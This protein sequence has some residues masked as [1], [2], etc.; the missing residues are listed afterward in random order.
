VKIDL[1]N[2]TAVLAALALSI[3]GGRPR[4]DGQRAIVADRATLDPISPE[5]LPDG[6]L[7]LRDARGVLVPLRK[8]DRIASGTLISD[9]ALLDLCEPDRIVAFTRYASATPVGHRYAGKPTISGRDDVERVLALKPQL[10]L[11]SDLVDG[12]YVSRLRERG[13][14]VFDLGP[15][16][17]LET[18][19]HA[20]HSIGWLIG[21]PERAARYA[22][23][24]QLRLARV[25]DKPP[26]RGPSTL[27]LARYGDKLFAAGGHTSYHDV[28]EFAGLHDAAAAHGLN[29]WPELTA[30]RVLEL[31]PE[32]MLT[33]TGM[34][35][36]LCRHPGLSLS[37]PCRGEGKILELD[38]ALLDDPGPSM[39]DAAEA[40][41]RTYMQA[42]DRGP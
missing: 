33:R 17:G 30:E 39:L 25:T 11:V 4:D 37:R 42:G 13:V 36:S 27:Y 5:R 2:L 26:A 8:Y 40:L 12:G 31:D 7:A 15:M 1:V 29:G 22:E 38:G 28:I 20:L 6:S 10:L 23:S 16:Q 3:V 9:R 34:S 41:H 21:A 24:L 35:A 14:E 32:I 19:L 18:L